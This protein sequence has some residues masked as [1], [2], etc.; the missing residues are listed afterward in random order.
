MKLTKV[1]KLDLQ[2]FMKAFGFSGEMSGFEFINWQ[3][4]NSFNFCFQE[5]EF[6]ASD[7]EGTQLLVTQVMPSQSMERMLPRC[8]LQRPSS[9]R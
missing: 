3:S 4:P 5:R 7:I 6:L 2:Q 1:R 8:A 9:V